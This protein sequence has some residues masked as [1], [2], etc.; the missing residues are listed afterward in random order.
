MGLSIQPTG[1]AD[2]V[3]I[4]H[5]DDLFLGT[6]AKKIIRQMDK[7]VYIQGSFSIALFVV[8]KMC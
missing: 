1:R 3:S 4:F 2:C 8:G 6:Y 5:P 7:D